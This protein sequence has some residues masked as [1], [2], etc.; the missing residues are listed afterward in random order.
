M[1]LALDTSTAACTV[2]LFE[3]DGRLSAERHLVIGRGH[4]EQLVP[5]VAEVVGEARPKRVLVGCGPG[6]FTGLRVGIAAAHGLAIGWDAAIAGISSLALLAAPHA[7][8]GPLA[9]VMSGGHGELFVQ[10]FDGDPLAPAGPLL[11][12]P[13]EA[14]A[15][16]IDAPLLVGPAAA[17]LQAARGWGEVVDSLPDAGFALRLPEAL[18]TLAP[19]PVYARAPDA[20]PKAA[21]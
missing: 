4:A 9:G 12:Q 21:A 6:S 13:A 16:M 17:A 10:A 15:A 11:N 8:K 14:A 18:R 7:G 5:M 1:I 19:Q 20:R 2:A 3:P